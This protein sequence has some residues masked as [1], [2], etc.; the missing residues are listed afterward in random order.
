MQ[1]DA[2]LTTEAAV[3]VATDGPRPARLTTLT[4]PPLKPGQAVV[5][6]AYSGV[7]HSQLN[8]AR[9]R[10]GLD[11]FLPHTFGHEAVGTVA[12]I[13]EGVTKV[14]PGD[15]VVLTWI[16]GTGA[17]VP[18]TVYGGPDG[19]VNSGAV[20]TFMRKTITCESRL[21]L[22]PP[23]APLREAVL[24]GC[25]LPT[26]GGVIR[27]TA[28]VKAG[29]AVAVFGVGGVG[30]AAVA[31]AAASG[32]APL[33]AVD[34]VDAK[35]ELALRLGASHAVNAGREDLLEAINRITGGRG[36]DLAVEAAGRPEAME[37]AFKA[38]R[39]GGGL[40]VLAGNVPFGEKLAIDP[41]DLIQGRR[42]LGS[43]G[44]ETDPDRDIPIYAEMLRDG[45]LRIEGLIS[46]V[47]ALSEVNEALDDLEAGRTMRPLIDMS[48]A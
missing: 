38:A 44:G 34:V 22:L 27:N 28:Q 6:I 8:E 11:R 2:A 15:A 18:S 25:A 40:C 10:R 48:L 24:L 12:V 20:S 7:C 39:R 23:G 4:L 32:A 41:Y 30:S 35:L 45:R 42:L 33:I 1:A 16:K 13:G 21:V 3:L 47:Y 5:D 31:V 46:R 43:W 9:G 36:V 37:A 14:R 29:D 19:P 17:D 26:G